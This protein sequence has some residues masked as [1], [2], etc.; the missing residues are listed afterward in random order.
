MVMAFDT[1]ERDPVEMLADEFVQRQRR[2]EKP[3]I[4]DYIERYPHLAPQIRNVFPALLALEKAGT[5]GSGSMPVGGLSGECLGGVAGTIGDYTILREIGRGAMGV[6]YEADQ[7]SLGRRVAL[8]VLPWHITSS[9]TAVERFRREARAAARLHHT[10]IVPVFDV[11]QEG[12]VCYYAM[13]YIQGQSLDRVLVELKRMRSGVAAAVD[14]AVSLDSRPPASQVALSLCSAAFAASELAMQGLDP[15]AGTLVQ[16]TLVGEPAERPKTPPAGSS[17]NR[18]GRSAPSAETARLAAGAIDTRAGSSTSLLESNKAHYYRSAAHIGRQVASALSYAHG[19][20]IIH[21]DIKPS[22]LLLDGAGVVWVTD[23]GLAKTE[24]AAITRTGDLLGTLRYMAPE[25]FSGECDAQA[26][27]YSLGATLYELVCL[28]P[29]FEAADSAGLINKICNTSPVAP[30][31]IDP[32]IPRDLECII[33]KAMERDR[34]H[35]YQSADGLADDLR[36]FL[37]DEPVLGRRVPLTERFARWARHNR[38]L[39]AVM[40]TAASLLLMAAIV[41]GIAS[42]SFKAMA[43][44][45]R[46]ARVETTNHL[47]HSL[48]QQAQATRLARRE[49]YRSEV[50]NMLDQARQLE[51]AEVDMAQLRRVAVQSLGDFVGEKP[52]V[53]EG[54]TSDVRSASFG[55]AGVIA[56]GLAD[57][58]IRWFDA[59]GKQVAEHKAHFATVERISYEPE[60]KTFISADARGMLKSWRSEREAWQPTSLGEVHGQPIALVAAR[61]GRAVIASRSEDNRTEIGIDVVPMRRK[62]YLDPGLRVE[63][64]AFNASGS[65]VALVAGD[66]VSVWQAE[67]GSL[68]ERVTTPLG[69]L[70]RPTFSRDGKLLFCGCDQ[71]LVVFELPELKQQTFMRYD[72]VSVGALSPDGLQAAFASQNRRITLWNIRGNRE[73]ATLVHPGWQEIHTLVLGDEGGLLASADAQSVRIWNLR[74]GKERTSIAGHAGAVTGIKL[75]RDG[76]RVVSGGKD[77]TVGLWDA[78]SGSLLGMVSLPGRVQAVDLSSDNRLVAADDNQGNLRLLTSP[79]LT[80]ALKI[81]HQLGGLRAVQFSPD[82]RWLAV[83]GEQGT[84]VW[85]LKSEDVDNSTRYWVEREHSQTGGGLN[86]AFSASGDM[87]AWVSDNGQLQAIEPATGIVW[88]LTAPRALRNTG[89]AFQTDGQRLLYI[90]IQG[91]LVSWNVVT[92]ALDTAI[93]SGDFHS[94]RLAATADGRWA[95]LSATPLQLAVYDLQKKEEFLAFRDERAAL[96]ASSWSGD[97]N[98]LAIGMQDGSLA[99][100]NLPA[101]RSELAKIKLDWE[102]AAAADA[103]KPVK[104]LDALTAALEDKPDD[105]RLLVRRAQIYGQSAE[106]DKALADLSKAIESDPNNTQA[107][108]TR[109]G[110]H[111]RQKRWSEAAADYRQRVVAGEASDDDWLTA[112]IY[113]ARAGEREE[114]RRHCEEMVTRLSEQ[115]SPA[116]VERV[117]RACLLISGVK[118]EMLPR[119]RLKL[120]MN[121]ADTTPEFRCQALVTLALAAMRSG[122]ADEALQLVRKAQRDSVYSRLPDVQTMSFLVLAMAQQDLGQT[123]L[124]KDSRKAAEEFLRRVPAGNDRL[125]LELLRDEVNQASDINNRRV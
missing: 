48:V 63:A 12:S 76:S 36:R 90:D 54:F 29:A 117:L 55:E 28:C 40:V 25:R 108:S 1:S 18:L 69:P 20:R 124:A 57:G 60:T 7:K 66:E 45:E 39:A 74:G 22:N 98:R 16:A 34:R 100:W 115:S 47:Y 81:E 62:V 27:V 24:E 4:A 101:I 68:I 37:D 3:N 38:T 94:G 21:R 102:D 5:S 59:R 91:R 77:G 13:Q 2:G 86:L 99:V 75:N 125:G 23:F 31:E 121:R 78:E 114:Y 6:V 83:C 120:V 11:G 106:H 84:S 19:R 97:G 79:R 61:E 109:A 116:Q 107:L 44:K 58:T 71:G 93:G 80:E 35:R 111:A 15:E 30:R 72:Q 43:S 42:A 88:P 82:N 95:A 85:R 105:A 67:T 10:N 123:A 56:V 17:S 9:T 92:D 53:L 26:D 8:K 51:A 41:S 32:R 87:L 73:L 112:A 70:T 113:L 49:G 104:A 52:V 33:Q 122:D 89:L 65:Q 110:V 46:A 14:E 103:P 64:A 50:W 96:S 119:E 118:Q